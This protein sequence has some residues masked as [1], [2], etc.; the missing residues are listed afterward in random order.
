MRRRWKGLI[1]LRE[2]AKLK[3]LDESQIAASPPIGRPGAPRAFLL[4]LGTCRSPGKQAAA[5][6]WRHR[7]W[8]HDREQQGRGTMR[9]TFALLARGTRDRAMPLVVYVML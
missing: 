6:S 3:Q 7:L 4:M 9:R 2:A 8:T 1:G 5:W